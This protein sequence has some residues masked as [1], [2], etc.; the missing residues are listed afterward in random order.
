MVT[1]EVG[2]ETTL[3]PDTQ[4]VLLLCGEMGQRGG[5]GMKPLGLRQY[6]ALASW[7]KVQGMRPGDLLRPEGRTRLSTVDV[8]EVDSD[9]VVPLLDRGAALAM[10]TERWE[11]SGLGSSVGAIRVIRNALNDIWARLHRRFSMGSAPRIYSIVAASSLSGHAT[12]RKRMGSLRAGLASIVRRKA[13]L[14]F[15]GQP[16]ESTVTRCPVRLRSAD[17]PWE[18]SQKG[19]P[20]Q[21]LRG[22]TARASL[23]IV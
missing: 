8:Q 11:R 3:T 4:A 9:R 19:W 14:L 7:L 10:V 16:R 18:F 2:M 12:A 6:N 22:S 17:G 13:S 20:R 15:L 1:S 5:N 23:V 21:L